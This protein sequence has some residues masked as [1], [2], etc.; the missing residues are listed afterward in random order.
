MSS[1][2]IDQ[3]INRSIRQSINECVSV[4]NKIHFFSR[5]ITHSITC[6]VYVLIK[7]YY[8][9]LLQ[10]LKAKKKLLIKNNNSKNDRKHRQREFFFFWF[11]LTTTIQI[12][13]DDHHDN[14]H[15]I[16]NEYLMD[17]CPYL[18]FFVTTMMMMMM[19]VNW[20]G[21]IFIT[22][23][24]VYLHIIQSYYRSSIDDDDDVNHWSVIIID[25]KLMK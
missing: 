3:S 13:I 4:V 5:L 9:S 24:A 25:I 2:S 12:I 18:W 11:F 22:F 17:R 20:H 16:V 10:T 8:N 21:L 15:S 1:M 6:N 7:G 14:I 23:S 19:M